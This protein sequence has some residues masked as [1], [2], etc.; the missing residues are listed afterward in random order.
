MSYDIYLTD[1]VNGAVIEFDEPHHMRGGT[2]QLGGSRAAHLNITYNYGE[3]FRR[4]FGDQGIRFLYNMSGADSIPIL[5]QAISEL[6]DG[7]REDYWKATEGNVKAA[8]LQLVALAKMRPDGV[9][10]GD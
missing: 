5:E 7:T 2:Y 4:C 10:Q 3:I 6:K 8:L 9:W 1:P